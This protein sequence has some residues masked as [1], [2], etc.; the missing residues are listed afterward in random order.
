MERASKG[1]K[2]SARIFQ[3]QKQAPLKKKIVLFIL[4][5]LVYAVYSKGRR[6][7][8]MR[9]KIQQEKKKKENG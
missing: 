6:K 8:G 1:P 2:E 7:E 3:F 9:W 4:T 5:Q